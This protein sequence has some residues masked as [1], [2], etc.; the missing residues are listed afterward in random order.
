MQCNKT[1]IGRTSQAK[2]SKKEE[3]NTHKLQSP[4]KKQ[5]KINESLNASSTS[6]SQLPT[7]FSQLPNIRSII[8]SSLFAVLAL[9][10]SLLLL[11]H[12]HHPL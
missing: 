12:R 3:K 10:P 4:S 5:S 11:G 7:K 9:H 8:T 2:S 1:I 6:S